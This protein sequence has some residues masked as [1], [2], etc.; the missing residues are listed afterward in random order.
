M[1]FLPPHLMPK[2][3]AL[4]IFFTHSFNPC[5]S[6]PLCLSH[7][8][9]FID[10]PPDLLCTPEQVLH[11]IHQ[12]PTDTSPGP[13]GISSKML[14]STAYSILHPLSLLFN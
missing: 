7:S 12:L 13:D 11:L 2:T 8:L 5:T 14:K 9:T 1:K 10:P 4:I 6:S 3:T